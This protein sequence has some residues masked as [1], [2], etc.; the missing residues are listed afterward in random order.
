VILNILKNIVFWHIQSSLSSNIV[1]E[2]EAGVYSVEQAGVGLG[3]W[4]GCRFFLVRNQNLK[5][6]VVRLLQLYI[7]I[8]IFY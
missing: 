3:R 7:V 4:V 8:I 1:Y 5:A 2:I 6:L